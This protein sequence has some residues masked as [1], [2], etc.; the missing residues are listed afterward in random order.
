MQKQIESQAAEH[1]AKLKELEI[2]IID[3]ESIIPEDQ[4]ERYRRTVRQ[5]GADA[6]AASR[7]APA[8]LLRLSPRRCST[9]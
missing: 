4:R 6:L 8:G 9:T 2:A 3:A 5:L 7:T 1:Q